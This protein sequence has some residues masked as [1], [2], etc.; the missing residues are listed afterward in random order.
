MND[1]GQSN[2]VALTKE[3]EEGRRGHVARW[4]SSFLGNTDEPRTEVSCEVIIHPGFLVIPRTRR[5]P[6]PKS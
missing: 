6:Q 3:G 4:T 5:C 1:E 2:A